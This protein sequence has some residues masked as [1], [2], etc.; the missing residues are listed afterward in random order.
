MSTK[1]KTYTDKVY[2]LIGGS[3]P[4]S[5]ILQ[6]KHTERKPLL[7]FDESHDPPIN[8]ELRYASNQ[9]S[10]FVDEQDGQSRMSPIIFEDGFLRVPRTNPLLQRFLELHPSNGYVF[11]EVDES[12]DAID[13]N[14]IYD[15]EDEARERAAE[16]NISELEIVAK[17]ALRLNT[18]KMTSPEI[19]RDVRKYAR[20][21]PQ[22]FLSLLSDPDLEIQGIVS[23]L[24]AERILTKKNKGRDIY[25]N[26]PSNKKR[27]LVVPFGEDYIDTVTSYLKS[28]DGIETFRLLED[29]LNALKE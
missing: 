3:A 11:V 19:K 26:L 15:L 6:A 22:E 13:E 18:D 24:F 8:R 12:K 27:M 29:K 25:F 21:Y 1:K 10:P 9:K 7:Y 16:M 23:E 5:V 28:D 17:V 20:N 2:K 14:A 4:L